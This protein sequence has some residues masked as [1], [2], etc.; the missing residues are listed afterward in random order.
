KD[1]DSYNSSRRSSQSNEFSAAMA[2]L[3]KAV[4]EIVTT[5]TGQ[6]SDRATTLLDDTATRLEAELR[7]RKTTDD[8]D[9]GERVAR[10]RSR[11]SGR[12]RLVDRAER[13]NPRSGHLY[14]DIENAKIG[15]VCA[16]IARYFGLQTWTTR[17][18]A[19]TG[20]LFLPGIVFPAYWIAYFIMD[21]PDTED[22]M[23]AGRK[24]RTSRSDETSTASAANTRRDEVLQPSRSLRYTNADLTQAELRLRR[25]ESFVTSDQYEL[26]R[27]LTKIEREQEPSGARS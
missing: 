3:E 6:L 9:T 17:L 22:S 11:N 12:H 19:L 2:R 24:T 8:P 15:G 14:R 23:M 27:E 13:V 4:A 7:F 25:L 26:H 16:G 1:R 10:R 5:T 20:L 18:A 21:K